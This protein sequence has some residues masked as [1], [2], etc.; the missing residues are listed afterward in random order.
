M[1]TAL[2]TALALAAS[3]HVLSGLR[4]RLRAARPETGAFAGLLDELALPQAEAT[5]ARRIGLARAA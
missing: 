1:I 2:L 3:V 5:P 4:A